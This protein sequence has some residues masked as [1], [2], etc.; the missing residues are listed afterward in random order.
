M[1]EFNYGYAVQIQILQ[2]IVFTKELQLSKVTLEGDSVPSVRASW[3]LR[4]P[5]CFNQL[6]IDFKDGGPSGPTIAT[7]CLHDNEV[8]VTNELTESS[9]AC[10]VHIGATVTV[11]GGQLDEI[12]NAQET[13]YTGGI[14]IMFR[15]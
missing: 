11:S 13:I 9:F 2:D 14:K 6:C 12:K 8:T 3:E 7:Q 5:G 10:N 1:T 15:Y 4:Y